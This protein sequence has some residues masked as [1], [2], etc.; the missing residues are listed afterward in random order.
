M[1]NPATSSG[2]KSADGA[3]LAMT[4]RLMG[5]Q[6]IADGTNAG[7]IILYDNAS[8][9]S[10]NVL[11]KASVDAGLTDVSV[12]LPAAGIVANNGIYLDIGGTGAECIVYFC[13][14]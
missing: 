9:A 4:G 1:I 11:A 2:I 12:N 14:G 7:T 5:V 6:I 3:I 10:G 8:A 13:A